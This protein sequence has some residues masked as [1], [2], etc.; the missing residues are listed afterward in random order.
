LKF[1]L[2]SY[3]SHRVIVEHVN[4]ALKNTFSSLKELRIRIK[5]KETLEEASNWVRACLILYNINLPR[6][7][8]QGQNVDQNDDDDE[9]GISQAQNGKERRTRLCAWVMDVVFQDS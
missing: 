8:T 5:G 7:D 9:H 3:S 1:E 6:K 2:L 4:G